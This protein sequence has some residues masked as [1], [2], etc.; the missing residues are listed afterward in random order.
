MD[1]IELYMFTYWMHM[2]HLGNFYGTFNGPK[3]N[4]ETF[5]STV[6]QTDI[7]TMTKEN[8]YSFTESCFGTYE[9]AKF[10]AICL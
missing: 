7:Q 4:L 2:Y 10:V 1:V 8:L 6:G 9:G 3:P 5:L